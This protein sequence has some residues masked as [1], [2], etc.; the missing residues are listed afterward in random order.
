MFVYKIATR[1]AKY[2]LCQ[3]HLIYLFL[4][5]LYN[6]LVVAV[7]QFKSVS[8]HHQLR[9]ITQIKFTFTLLV[10]DGSHII[11]PYT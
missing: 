7:S 4:S 2:D 3:V 9:T 6:K 8:C 11:F 1:S 10:K 5:I